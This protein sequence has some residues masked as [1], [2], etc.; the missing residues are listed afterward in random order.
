MLKLELV[1]ELF[2]ENN[3]KLCVETTVMCHY[4]K[5]YLKTLN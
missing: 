1:S 3:F 5:H 4:L 2:P